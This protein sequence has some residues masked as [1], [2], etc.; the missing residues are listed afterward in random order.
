MFAIC[1]QLDATVI[2]HQIWRVFISVMTYLTLWL[3]FPLSFSSSFDDSF[4]PTIVQPHVT[5]QQAQERLHQ[6][7]RIYLHNTG[8]NDVLFS[9][10][11]RPYACQ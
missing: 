1:L 2:D 10:C 4:V 8:C 9:T 11:C 5:L 7:S 3:P 6:V